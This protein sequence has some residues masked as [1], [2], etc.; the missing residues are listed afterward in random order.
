MSE[1]ESNV[2]ILCLKLLKRKF[3]G[4]ITQDELVDQLII[5]SRKHGFEYWELTSF[6]SSKPKIVGSDI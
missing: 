2:P 3:V 5:I 4:E 1:N 6:Y